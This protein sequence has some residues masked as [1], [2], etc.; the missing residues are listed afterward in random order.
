MVDKATYLM[1]NVNLMVKHLDP[2]MVRRIFHSL[3]AL[4]VWSVLTN[5]LDIMFSHSLCSQ[6]SV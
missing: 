4:L 5:T 3:S 2:G 6:M 1:D